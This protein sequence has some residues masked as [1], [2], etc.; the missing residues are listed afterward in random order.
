MGKVCPVGRESTCLVEKS[1]LSIK[2][3]ENADNFFGTDYKKIA[4]LLKKFE[5]GFEKIGVFCQ[6]LITRN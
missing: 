1:M 3:F 5:P 6:T 2:Q 4:P